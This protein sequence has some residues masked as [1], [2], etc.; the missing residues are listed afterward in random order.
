MVITRSQSGKRRKT[1]EATTSPALN[2]ADLPDALLST[3]AEYLS[4]TSTALFSAAFSSQ[5][6]TKE[7][8]AR[9]LAIVSSLRETSADDPWDV[10]DF[11]DVEKSLRVKLT[12]DD[13]G[14]MLKCIDA[15]NKLRVL[16]LTHCF[17]VSGRGLEPLRGSA[18]LEQ[19]DLS[20]VGQ[21]ER[22]GSIFLADSEV[23]PLI[24]ESS[25]LPILDSIIDNE[26]SLLQH[27]QFPHKWRNGECSSLDAFHS[28]LERYDAFLTSRGLCSHCCDSIR[29]D[30][31][32]NREGRHYGLQLLT[33]CVCMKTIC[34]TCDE[35]TLGEDLGICTRCQKV[36]CRSCKSVLCCESGSC[37]M[38]SCTGCGLVDYCDSC[39]VYY[40]D[41][42]GHGADY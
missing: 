12:D 6:F 17:N 31:M 2:I 5:D 38:K 4:T 25:V 20:L 33:C 40:C 11:L 16:K 8:S 42:C 41:D 22:P 26:C 7:P 10:V 21:H 36:Y 37:N 14:G 35:L 19:L 28:F 9:S 32:L 1:T 13:I 29:R 15:T 24:S 3:V 23:S 30:A 34:E 18:A 27:L 39:D